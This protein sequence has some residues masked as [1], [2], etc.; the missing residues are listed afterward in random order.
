MKHY[1]IT[2]LGFLL[3]TVLFSCK[4]NNSNAINGN[5]VAQ[6]QVT[7]PTANDTVRIANDSLEY[8]VIIIDPGFTGW[9]ASRAQP[10][11]YY[12]ESYLRN[13]NTIWTTEWN[14]RVLNAQ[15][16]GNMYQMRI[17]YSPQIEYGYEVNYLI[18]NY[19]VYFQITNN[20]RLGG[21]VPQF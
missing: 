4:T 8:E 14:S 21:I 1:T 11:G 13:K 3:F 7:P 5:N 18:Y 16:F 2:L 10:R 12:G 19:L 20:Q 9:L 6:N 17:D 15:R